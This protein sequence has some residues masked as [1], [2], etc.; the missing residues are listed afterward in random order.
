METMMLTV[1]ELYEQGLGA[2]L[3]VAGV[4][5]AM[6]LLYAALRPLEGGDESEEV[7]E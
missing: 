6:A 1:E 5:I 2:V 3:L 7:S 4:I